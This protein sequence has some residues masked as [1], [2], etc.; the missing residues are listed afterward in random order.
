MTKM[1]IIMAM[2]PAKVQKIAAVSKRSQHLGH[3]HKGERPEGFNSHVEPR[4]PAVTQG[5]D[6][7]TQQSDAEEDEKDLVGFT[8]ENTDAGLFLKHIDARDEEQSRAKVHS[9]RDG[10]VTDEV[11][12]ATDPAGYTPPARGSQHEGLVVDT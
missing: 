9:K 6:S 3:S 2:T 5:G 11:E 7:I 12:P 1:V 8:S 10:D 4:Q